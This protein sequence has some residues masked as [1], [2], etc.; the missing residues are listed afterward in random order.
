M[1]GLHEQ[2]G[3]LPV[4]DAPHPA[5]S[6]CCTWSG[7]KNDVGGVAGHAVYTGAEGVQRAE[8][9]H[10]VASVGIDLNRLRDALAAQKAMIASRRDKIA[11]V[12]VCARDVPSRWRKLH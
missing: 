8:F 3:V 11:H 4:T 6:T 12:I 9:I 7:R 5:D 2:L 1:P 10:D